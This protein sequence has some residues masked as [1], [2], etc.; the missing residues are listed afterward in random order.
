MKIHC[1]DYEGPP[2]DIWS[3]GII[4]FA[5]LAGSLYNLVYST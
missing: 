2:V 4:L 5:L 1:M 3:S